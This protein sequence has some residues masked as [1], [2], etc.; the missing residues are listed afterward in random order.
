[1]KEEGVRLLFSRIG[2]KD[3]EEISARYEV[4]A[5]VLDERVT[6]RFNHTVGAAFPARLA[7]TRAMAGW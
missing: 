6:I 7:R 1:V 4:K 3:G 5:W 2:I